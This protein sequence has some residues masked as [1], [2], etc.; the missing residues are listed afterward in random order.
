V[1]GRLPPVASRRPPRRRLGVRPRARGAT[2]RPSGD[3]P[4]RRASPRWATSASRRPPR[5]TSARSCRRSSSS[6][7]H[8]PGLRGI[9]EPTSLTAVDV[10]RTGDADEVRRLERALVT[11]CLTCSRRLTPSFRPRP[12]G[13]NRSRSRH[14]C[15]TRVRARCSREGS[16]GASPTRGRR[17]GDAGVPTF[18]GLARAMFELRR[19]ASA[20][21]VTLEELLRGL[22]MAGIEVDG[23]DPNCTLADALSASQ[24]DRVWER[25]DGAT[26]LSG[27]R[28]ARPGTGSL[29]KPLADALSDPV[30]VRWPSGRFHHEEARVQL[31]KTGVRVWA[32]AA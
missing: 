6:C 25:Q 9:V 18:T 4:G 3:R 11:P 8:E 27:T 10:A 24:A 12:S 13:P 32:P 30:R 21:G 22:R 1:E 7:S 19:G 15:S 28:L 5:S 17:E 2:D 16:L 26:W 23:D 29:A 14:T 20:D 31:E